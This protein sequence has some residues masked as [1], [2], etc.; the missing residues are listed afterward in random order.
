MRV[1]ALT[2]VVPC[3]ELH[4]TAALAYA[5]QRSAGHPWSSQA[6]QVQAGGSGREAA[7]SASPFFTRLSASLGA[8]SCPWIDASTA[9]AG[10]AS[11]GGSSSMRCRALQRLMAHAAASTPTPASSAL[12][13]SWALLLLA[14]VSIAASTAA[15]PA[16]L[17]T[18]EYSRFEHWGW[19]GEWVTLT[20]VLPDDVPADA[21][22]RAALQAALQAPTQLSVS[23]E[24]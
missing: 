11:S 14:P 5:A 19:G 10:E 15:T 17:D 22:K 9:D 6:A 24:R 16:P 3:A 23:G 2:V 7:G 1:W 12:L 20:C 4:L 21:M 13:E 8:G 18:L